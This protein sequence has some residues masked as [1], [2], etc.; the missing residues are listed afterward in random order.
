MRTHSHTNVDFRRVRDRRSVATA[1]GAQQ[2]PTRPMD[3][4]FR[5]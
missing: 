1:L 2:G 4:P 5:S 3:R